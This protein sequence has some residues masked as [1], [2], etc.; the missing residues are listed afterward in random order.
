MKIKIEIDN[1]I[2]NDEIIIKCPKLDENIQKLQ[3]YISNINNNKFYFYKN[4]TEYFLSLQDILFFE[5]DSNCIS[6][7]TKDDNYE[8]RNKLYEL[9]NLLPSNFMRIS[10][11]TIINIRQIFSIEKN[12]TSSSII[13]FKNSYKQ[14]YVSRMYYKELKKKMEENFYE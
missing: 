8:T 9:E 13:K 7:H 14:A 6:A 5:T 3:N 4:D 12:I 2:D 1:N 11:S 10:K